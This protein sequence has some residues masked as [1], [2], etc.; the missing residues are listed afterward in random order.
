MT[1]WVFR[2]WGG[3]GGGG[4]EGGKGPNGGGGRGVFRIDAAWPPIGHDDLAV[5]RV[6][7]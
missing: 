5:F 7:F 2:E 6:M 1:G 3:G 4:G